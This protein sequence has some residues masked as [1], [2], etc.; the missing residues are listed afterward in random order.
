MANP[1][2]AILPYIPDEDKKEEAAQA[3]H[4]PE[5]GEGFKEQVHALREE[6]AAL[7]DRLHQLE[8]T[9]LFMVAQVESLT[10]LW[11]AHV[12]PKADP[13]ASQDATAPLKSNVG[14]RSLASKAPIICQ[15]LEPV[16]EQIMGTELRIIYVANCLPK[17]VIMKGVHAVMWKLGFQYGKPWGMQDDVLRATLLASMAGVASFK[18]LKNCISSVQTT[19]QR[20]NRFGQ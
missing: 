10:G 4:T 13:Q 1:F 9:S 5:D 12:T 11:N 3:H 7:R 16:E 6:N 14:A 18:Q 20:Q 8:E 15:Q 17:D 2:S 19:Q